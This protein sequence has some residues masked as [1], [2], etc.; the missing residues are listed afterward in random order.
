MTAEQSKPAGAGAPRREVEAP[1]REAQAHGRDQ[2]RPLAGVKVVELAHWMAGPLAAGLMGDWGADVIKIEPPGGDPMRAIYASLGARGDAP[3]GAF[4]VANRGKRSIELEIK[5]E[6]GRDALDKLLAGADVLLTNLRPDALERLGLGPRATCDRYPRL[7]YC[8]LSAYGLGGPDQDRPGYDIAA[9][10]GRTG[11]AHE[12][13]TAGSP[14]AALMQGIGDSFTALSAVTGVLAALL[15]REKTGRGR[16]VEA[17]LLRTGMW[18][19]AGEL[20]V[21]ALGGNPRPPYPRDQSRTPLYNSYRT[22]DERWF[23]LVGVEAKRH[24]GSVLK[25][26]GRADL[27]DDERFRSARGIAKNRDTLIPMFDA[28]FAAQPMAYWSQKFDE[29]DVWW[30]P[31][32]TPAEVVDD[33]QAAASGG[34]IEVAAGEGGAPVKSVDSPIRFDGQNRGLGKGPPKLGQHTRE[35]LDELGYKDVD[36]DQFSG[37]GG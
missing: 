18:A 3:N 13:T 14:P 26:I 9:F 10:F 37:G 27:L 23:F 32:Q 5:N 22:A 28:A 31:V 34:W 19:L 2:A 35:I 15:E 8:T 25:A 16:V 17:S 29:F 6:P 36:V 4:I 12:I 11:I 20:G 21:Q 24:I 1:A 7:V 30:A 33:R